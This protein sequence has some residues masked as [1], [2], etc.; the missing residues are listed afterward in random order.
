MK[1]SHILFGIL[2][3]ALLLAGCSQ[4]APP[5]ANNTPPAQPPPS[6]P[7]PAQPP[8]QP[9][10]QP[11]PQNHTNATI[12]EN[13]FSDDLGEALDDLD[14]V[15]DPS[16]LEQTSQNTFCD[17]D[18]DCWCKIFDGAHFQP[19]K[20]QWHCDLAKNRCDQCIYK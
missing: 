11:P 17:S 13:T 7:P 19:G 4:Q 16:D 9:P 18:S 3:V 1:T 8:S 12:D 15:T 2:V 20:S 14:A 10:V 6:Q 5:K